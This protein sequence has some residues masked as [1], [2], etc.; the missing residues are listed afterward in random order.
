MLG[1]VIGLMIFD[2]RHWPFQGHS[3]SL[4]SCIDGLYALQD[5]ATPTK[6]VW[7][8]NSAWSLSLCIAHNFNQIVPTSIASQ[9]SF[10]EKKSI[11]IIHSQQEMLAHPI[12]CSQPRSKRCN[13][14]LK[15]PPAKHH[16]MLDSSVHCQEHMATPRLA[17][18]SSK[19]VRL[20][21]STSPI[22][23][24][25]DCTRC[26]FDYRCIPLT[27]G[28]RPRRRRLR[29]L[30]VSIEFLLLRLRDLERIDVCPELHYLAQ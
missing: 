27:R 15:I 17:P 5:L 23:S 14:L 25:F 28:C 13:C 21:A 2:S 1:W 3:C 9:K 22:I 8:G 12:S 11:D 10:V 24:R 7:N 30:T 16:D 20:H 6:T 26:S 29:A 19:V 18:S 4:K